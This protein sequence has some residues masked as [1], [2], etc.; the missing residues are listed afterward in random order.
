MD[1][2]E[3]RILK[4]CAKEMAPK[5][6]TIFRK[7]I[8]SGEVPGQWK[9][10]HVIPIHKSGSKA[11]MANFRPVALTSAICKVLEKIVCSAIMSFL[12]KNGLLRR[13]S[14]VSFKGVHDKRT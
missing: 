4:E 10:A 7:S 5:L 14:M 13:N 9:E 11:V 12:T 3:N 1:G 8:D 2:V 6:K